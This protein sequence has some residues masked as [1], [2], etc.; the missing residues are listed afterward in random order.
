MIDIVCLIIIK[1]EFIPAGLVGSMNE[2][3]LEKYDHTFLTFYSPVIT[4][5][6]K[7]QKQK[8]LVGI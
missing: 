3:G 8:T 2:A 6:P 7:K 5:P 1:G 4:D